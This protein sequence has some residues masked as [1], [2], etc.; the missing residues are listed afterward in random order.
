MKHQSTTTLQWYQTFSKKVD[1]QHYQSY[2]FKRKDKD[3]GTI[4]THL[5]YFNRYAIRIQ[6]FAVKSALLKV[7]K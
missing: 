1:V 6:M 3:E 2:N 4:T 5:N 7:L